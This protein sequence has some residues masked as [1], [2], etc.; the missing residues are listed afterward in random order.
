MHETDFSQNFMWGVLLNLQSHFNIHLCWT[1]LRITT[2][3]HICT[4]VHTFKRCH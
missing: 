2:R 3:K 4:S 1:N